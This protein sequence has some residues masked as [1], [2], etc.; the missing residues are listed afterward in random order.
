MIIL[1]F[2]KESD[3][4]QELENEFN[5]TRVVLESFGMETVI[6]VIIPLAAILAP[7][8]SPIIIKALESNQVTIKHEGVEYTGSIKNVQKAI[9][10]MQKSKKP[11]RKR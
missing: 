11:G 8:V 1:E 7:V 5:T 6:Q 4:V 3:L 2:N 9:Q 10:E